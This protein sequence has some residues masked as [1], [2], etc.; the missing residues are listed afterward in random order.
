[1]NTENNNAPSREKKENM[2]SVV[3]EGSMIVC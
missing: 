3:V 2:M 1:M